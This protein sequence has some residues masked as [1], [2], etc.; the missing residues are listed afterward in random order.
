MND[1]NKSVL[2]VHAHP[3]DTEA[4]CAG[5]LKLL[6]D[7]GYRITIATMTGGGMGSFSTDEQATV[8]RRVQEAE[9]AAAV[10]G[11]EYYC[12]GGRDGFLFDSTE[13]RV[14]AVDLI[15]R[16]EAGVIMTHLPD[17]YHSDHRST[18]NIVEIA[19]MLA[20]LPNVPCSEPAL[21][22]PPLLYHTAPLG[23]SD[24]L[25]RQAVPQFGIDISS[26]IDTKMEMLSCHESQV[27]LMLR[28]QGMDNFFEEMKQYNRS[29][30][31]HCGCEYAEIFWQHLGGGVLKDCLLQ[32]ELKD[33]IKDFKQ[34]AADER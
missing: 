31:E 2:A 34:G 4:F 24:Q 14:A 8:E 26:V 30:G 19:T 33:Y 28:Q 23:F 10:I 32:D 16:V 29:L 21:K 1:F 27:E 17:D 15:R 6:K 3:D 18:S 9:K 5:T 11:A 13:M 7:K 25:G 22:N 20:T 12:L